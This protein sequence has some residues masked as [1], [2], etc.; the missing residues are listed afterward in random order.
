[1]KDGKYDLVLAQKFKCT[2]ISIFFFRFIVNFDMSSVS[3]I[4]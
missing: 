2:V 3:S 4:Y 1:M